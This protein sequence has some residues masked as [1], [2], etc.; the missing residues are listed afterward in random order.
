MMSLVKIFESGAQKNNMAHFAAIVNIAAVD[1]P[2]NTVEEKLLIRFANKLDISEAQFDEA[3][4]YPSNYPIN[5]PSSK[6]ERLEYLYDLF[7]MIY[8]DHEIDEPEMNLIR[9]YAIGLGCSSGTAKEVIKK[10]I[11]IFSG[12]IDF[13]DYR[14]LINKKE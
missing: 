8:A 4:R 12:K 6:E 2:I 14:Y 13:E 9:R 3:M 11:Q 1:G 5:P 10:S 7:K